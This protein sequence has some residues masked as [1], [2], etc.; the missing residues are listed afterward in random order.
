MSDTVKELLEIYG[1]SPTH[2]G[3]GIS[4]RI[5]SKGIGLAAKSDDENPEFHKDEIK[6][7]NQA[8]KTNP[9]W[10]KSMLPNMKQRLQNHMKRY[11][12]LTGKQY[13]AE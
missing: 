12:Q 2:A 8:I 9:E 13:K 5:G 6:S 3:R 4:Q 11:E 7:L 1:R 10:A